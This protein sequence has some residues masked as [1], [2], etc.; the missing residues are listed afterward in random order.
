MNKLTQ[1]TLMTPKTILFIGLLAVLAVIANSC[2]SS[3]SSFVEVPG[4]IYIEDKYAGYLEQSGIDVYVFREE[5]IHSLLTVNSSDNKLPS[6]SI[7]FDKLPYADAIAHTR[8]GPYS[9]S[10]KLKLPKTGSYIVAA[11][12]PLHYASVAI[13]HDPHGHP[14]GAFG[15]WLVRL[16]ADHINSEEIKLN[17]TNMVDTKSANTI[18]LNIDK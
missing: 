3:A 11:R 5:Q 2:N 8:S 16:P 13:L 6:A 1:S 7:F 4:R 15:Y 17:D 10:F 12:I 9:G 14:T 18:Q